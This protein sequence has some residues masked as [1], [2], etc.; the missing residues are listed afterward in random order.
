MTTRQP[1]TIERPTAPPIALVCDS[2][3]SG[4]TYFPD[5]R[6]AIDRK[7]LRQVEDTH[8]EALWSSVPAVGGALLHAHF[9]RSYVDANRGIDDIDPQLL[10]GV[11]PGPLNPGE[12]TRLG[13]GLIWRKVAA[14]TPI[15]DR[16]LPVAEVQARLD[17]CYKPYH[18]ALASLIEQAFQA[19]G[20]VWHLNLH[21]MPNNAYERLRIE[22]DH[23][24][25]DFVLG[26][27]DGTTSDPAFV[28][29]LEQELRARGYTVARNDP[30]K[31]VQLIAN[32]GRPALLRYSLQIEIRRPLYMDEATRE[33]NANFAA[34]QADLRD[35]TQ[36]LGKYVT[37][38]TAPR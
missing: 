35:I 12:K 25:A 37:E 27:R 33:R 7:R 31:G 4:R 22:H 24:L 14:D 16:L 30:Y 2:P 3:H 15:Y 11:W 17:A 38:R 28:D 5:F 19:F 18:A 32:I 9:P 36:V 21:S 26:D 13:S 20:S 23:P 34:V 6:H 29:V 1:F 8:V 10:D